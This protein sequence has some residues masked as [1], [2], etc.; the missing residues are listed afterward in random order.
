MAALREGAA[1]VRRERPNVRILVLS[2]YDF[3][4]ELR[5]KYAPE[6]DG[7]GGLLETSR[8]LAIA[9]ESVGSPRPVV[10]NTQSSFAVGAP[11][12]A[13]WPES[14]QGDT[15]GASAEIGQAVQTHVLDRL[16]E[17]VRSNLA[18]EP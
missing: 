18:A 6:S 5:G 4:Y 11:T 10:V 17:V 7:H 15:R 8:V 3:V 2:D 1:R 16:T 13:E 9:P 12:P 14:V